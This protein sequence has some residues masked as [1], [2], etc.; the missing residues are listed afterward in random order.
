MKAFE[1]S[2]RSFEEVLVFIGGSTDE[3]ED[4][5]RAYL[6][7]SHIYRIM[8]K[9]PLVIYIKLEIVGKAKQGGGR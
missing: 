7:L 1:K 4:A 8:S 3:D 2:T 5:C 6:N 9:P